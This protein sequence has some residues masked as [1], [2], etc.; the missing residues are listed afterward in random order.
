[1]RLVKGLYGDEFNNTSA[2]MGLLCGQ[3]FDDD[4]VHNGGWYNVNGEKIGWGDLSHENFK[5]IAEELQ[6]DEAFIVLGR[7][8]SLREF[9]PGGTVAGRDVRSP[10]I[11][12]VLERCRYIILPRKFYWFPI[13]SENRTS[14]TSRDLIFEIIT[15]E[16][17]RE[18]ILAIL[19]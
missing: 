14:I 8:I 9:G 15:R 2:L 19:H 4:F 18:L 11:D 13:G 16:R 12:Y 7:Y 1:M 6:N 3:S 5:R 17:A 10:G